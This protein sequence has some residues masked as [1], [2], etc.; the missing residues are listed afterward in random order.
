[1]FM[2]PANLAQAVPASELLVVSR[3]GFEFV[4]GVGR[5]AGL[6]P[7]HAPGTWVLVEVGPIHPPGTVTALPVGTGSSQATSA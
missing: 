5:S 6:G 1:M 7:M 4:P 2:P 3:V